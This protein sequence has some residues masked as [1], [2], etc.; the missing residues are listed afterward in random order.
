MNK[1]LTGVVLDA[2]GTTASQLAQTLSVPQGEAFTVTVNITD[3][4]GTAWPMTGY[5]SRLTVRRTRLTS[6]E[7][8]ARAGVNSVTAGR[9]TFTGV[10]GDTLDATP[11]DYVF[12]IWITETATGKSYRVLPETDSAGDHSIFTVEDAITDLDGTVTYADASQRIV[13]MTNDGREEFTSEF[14][15][16]ITLDVAHADTS[17]RVWLSVEVVGGE[18]A[19]ATY[20]IV[21]TS[22]FTITMSRA[23]SGFVAWSTTP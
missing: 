7:L 21:S 6:T 9:V 1:A 15:R 8:F 13:G 14:Q 12:D 5:T 11:A 3:E 23:F 17:Y 20:E 2:S 4:G 19:G 22:T 16:T 10:E 18:W